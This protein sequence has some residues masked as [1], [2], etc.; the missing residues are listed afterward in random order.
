[1]KKS[2]LADAEFCSSE[3]IYF[4]YYVYIPA[5][6]ESH[7]DGGTGSM[8]WLRRR[9][10]V[11]TVLPGG[12]YLKVPLILVLV[13]FLNI[14]VDSL[15]PSVA[16][17]GHHVLPAVTADE[18]FRFQYSL[19]WG[20]LLL[21]GKPLSYV[22]HS[23]QDYPLTIIPGKHTLVLAAEPFPIQSCTFTVPTSSAIQTQAT[24]NKACLVQRQASDAE[25]ASVTTLAFPVYPS[26][27]LLSAQQQ[28]A[29]K[30]ATQAYLDTLQGTTTVQAGELY[31]TSRGAPVQ[32][33]RVPFQAHLRFVLDT[34]TTQAPHCSGP[35]LGE[36]C[37]LLESG[38]DCRL[39]CTLPMSYNGVAAGHNNW[40]VAVI[41]LPTWTY[42]DALPATGQT[43]DQQYTLLF[44]RW[45]RGQWIVG[46]ADPQ[47]SSLSDPGCALA[48]DK[49]VSVAQALNADHKGVQASDWTF[50]S[51]KQRVWG[52][53]ATIFL[54]DSVSNGGQKQQSKAYLLW[55]FG[56]L[57]AA[58]AEAQRLF[59]D[60]PRTSDNNVKLTQAILAS[61]ASVS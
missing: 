56:V 27:T 4:V 30:R 21:D 25:A 32:T 44:I 46:R 15:V 58:N 47:I 50:T 40:E 7:D 60:L 38:Q 61:P 59:P 34:D 48:V 13:V 29:L 20:T 52:C 12:W 45:E 22:P 55:R 36:R 49:V 54:R 33:A 10:V 24:S 37:Q 19:P 3:L 17:W 8:T 18:T 9:R 26:L 43:S 31:R 23:T 11:A 16:F 2:V 35:T 5:T 39:F 28:E 6:E 53:V 51:A 57:Q 41:T 42:D 14:A 1:V